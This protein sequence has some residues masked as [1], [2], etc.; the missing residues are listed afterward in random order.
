[1]RNPATRA[2]FERLDAALA[3]NTGSKLTDRQKL[4]RM[5]R[6]LFGDEAVDAANASEAMAEA[7]AAAGP[8]QKHEFRPGHAGAP[9]KQEPTVA[10]TTTNSPG[11]TGHT[12]G[13]A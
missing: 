7:A 8:D 3:K 5:R 2:V 4:D 1:M 9:A 11:T 10:A 6:L 12:L 13:G